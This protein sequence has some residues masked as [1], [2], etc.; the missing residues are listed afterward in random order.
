MRTTKYMVRFGL[1]FGI[2]FHVS[3]GDV[4]LK[5]CHS[6]ITWETANCGEC[7]ARDTV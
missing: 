1:C 4:W 3:D 5:M 2:N 6:S 7:L